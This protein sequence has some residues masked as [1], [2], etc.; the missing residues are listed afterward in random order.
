MPHVSQYL[1]HAAHRPDERRAGVLQAA[2]ETGAQVVVGTHA[3]LFQ[4][5]CRYRDEQHQWRVL[6]R[7]QVCSPHVKLSCRCR[8]GNSDTST[9]AIMYGDLEGFRADDPEKLSI[10]SRRV[11]NMRNQRLPIFHRRCRSR[12]GQVTFS[13]VTNVSDSEMAKPSWRGTQNLVITAP[14]WLYNGR[15]LKN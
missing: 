9:I 13:G 14:T 12:G 2:I 11:A 6:L 3:H 4:H 8:S 1:V 7:K 10:C 5:G 15:R